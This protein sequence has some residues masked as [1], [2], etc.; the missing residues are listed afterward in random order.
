MDSK[1]LS[2]AASQQPRPRSLRA[3]LAAVRR[4]RWIR[5]GIFSLI[6]IL[7]T[8]WL[9]NFWVLLLYPLF[10]DMYLTQYIPWGAWKN[11]KN[12]VLRT[13]AEW[14][15]AI[16]YALVLV[17]FI[18][19]FLF[20]NFQ[21]PTPSLEKSML[22]GDFLLV[23]KVHYG[24]RV[25]Q[26]PLH[27]P[28]T[29]N[30]F[31]LINTKSYIE[32]IQWPYHRLKGLRRIERND[33]VVFNVPVG[34]TV[35]SLMPNPDYYTLVHYYG[36]DALRRDKAR[37][38][39]IIYRPVDR[40]EAYVK[41]CIGLPGETFEM[42]DNVVYIDGKAIEQPSKM[43]LNYFVKTDGT[44]INDKTFEA[45]GV[46]VDDR[47]YTNNN[48]NAP[49]VYAR[50]GILPES[51]GTYNP[52]YHMPLTKEA[53]AK[54][55]AAPFVTQ[56]VA[57]PGDFGGDVF[58][59]DTLHRWTRS[60]FGPLWIPRKG[61]TLQL[62]PENYALYERAIRNYEGNTID[63]RNGLIYINGEP[64]NEYTFKMDYYM[65][66]GDNRDNSADSRYW[67]LVPEDHVI[68]TPVLVLISLDK[69]KGWFDG[70]FRFNRFMRPVES[71][72]K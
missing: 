64:T 38:G 62:M 42:K 24:P 61:A 39:E 59:L 33:I 69:D 67:G 26:T 37:F 12:P 47:A 72:V 56:V 25:P 13:I 52:V 1:K 2:A 14:V 54:V 31:P 4:T 34:D 9:G 48:G 10:F 58:P 68:G 41:R 32:S 51:N 63:L 17:Y 15:D 65:M 7:W 3:R 28:L 6:F 50:L 70:K 71:L 21:I 45:W 16:V 20:Q 66:L 43:Q 36:R 8:V 60:D 19:I 53:L 29:Q 57:E 55:K 18:F 11:V 44:M 35:A 5:F 40:R 46:S 30:T 23:S 27:F 22:V 49:F